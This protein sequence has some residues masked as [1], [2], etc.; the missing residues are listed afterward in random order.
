[1]VV[2][3][4]GQVGWVVGI[5][6][7]VRVGMEGVKAEARAGWAMVEEVGVEKEVDLVVVRV[8]EVAMAVGLDLAGKGWVAAK[9]ERVE[10]VAK[11]GVVVSVGR[12]WEV[13]VVVMVEEVDWV[14]RAR[15]VRAEVRE[16]VMV[17]MA[18]ET[19][20]LEVGMVEA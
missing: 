7:M 20:V 9:V 5:E 13:K 15:E 2:E 10:A 11:V 18:G 8:V 17:A 4:E 12:G 3:M 6:A 1:M 14:V 19:V 16:V